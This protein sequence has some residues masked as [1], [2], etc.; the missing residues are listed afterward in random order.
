MF[1]KEKEILRKAY[2]EL[3]EENLSLEAAKKVKD[4]YPN[5]NRVPKGVKSLRNIPLFGA[6]VSFPAEIVRKHLI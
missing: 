1:L 3:T 4:L 5:Y 6:F 2:P